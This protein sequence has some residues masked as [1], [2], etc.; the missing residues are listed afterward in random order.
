MRFEAVIFD[1]DGTLL[2][3]L[4]DIANSVNGVLVKRGLP[5][6]EI[7][8][9]RDF[10]GEGVI[11]LITRA[12]PVGERDDATISEVAEE[13]RRAYSRNWNV[14]SR[15][16]HGVIGMLQDLA[17]RD[18]KLSVLSN[19]PDDFTKQCVAELLPDCTFDVVMGHHSGIPR[20]P[21][22]AGAIQLA[23]ELGVPPDHMLFVGDS[24]TDMKTA[25]GA[26]IFPLG[27]LWGFRSQEEL[28]DNGAKLLIKHPN[29]LVLRLEDAGHRI[30]K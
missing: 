18:V 27:V 3:T 24:G 22:P 6:H 26:G 21:D 17:A 1:L 14:S 30:G 20:K 19:K 28:Q 25:V 23:Q 29:E 4:A 8:A 10:V 9:Y 16:Y 13:Y 5:Q 2:D 7:D 15:P 12:L 11:H